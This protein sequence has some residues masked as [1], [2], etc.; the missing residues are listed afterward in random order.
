MFSA[1]ATTC[2]SPQRD[3]TRSASI[4]SV[5]NSLKANSSVAATSAARPPQP[6]TEP[7]D[8]ATPDRPQ[9]GIAV[10][11]VKSSDIAGDTGVSEAG[12]RSTGARGKGKERALTL[13]MDP[14]AG[15]GPLHVYVIR[16][17][18]LFLG[19]Y[20]QTGS[21]LVSRKIDAKQFHSISAAERAARV[22]KGMVE[23]YDPRPPQINAIET[24]YEE[25]CA[26]GGGL[27]RGFQP[28]NPELKLE[29]LI[30]VDDPKAPKHQRSTIAIPARQLSADRVRAEIK[31]KREENEY[32]ECFA[33][34]ASKQA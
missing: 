8:S 10:A 6:T 13:P 33:E 11:R 28:G 18:G 29:P 25:M 21:V 14:L 16:I 17:N 32:F 1:N 20:L 31:R 30:F 7:G 4:I 23:T 22:L 15:F 3:S 5:E 27:Y 24:L 26:L 2:S 19:E 34:K 9:S 12:A